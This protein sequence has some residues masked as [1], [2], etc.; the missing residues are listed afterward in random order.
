M[1]PTRATWLQSWVM[2]QFITFSLLR[3][4]QRVHEVDPLN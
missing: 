2:Y 4:S 1:D 3:K